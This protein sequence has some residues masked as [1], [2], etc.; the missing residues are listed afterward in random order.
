M[1]IIKDDAGYAMKATRKLAS[2]FGKFYTPEAVCRLLAKLAYVP[3]AKTVYDPTCGTGSLLLYAYDEYKDPSIELIGQEINGE[4]CRLARE[5][6]TANGVRNFRID[7]GD[8][9]ADPAITEP[10]DVV[11]GKTKKQVLAIFRYLERDGDFSVAKG[12]IDEVYGE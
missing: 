12:I 9:L 7:E 8:T 3:N 2:E 10:V 1:K 11:L 6:M 4:S 5:N